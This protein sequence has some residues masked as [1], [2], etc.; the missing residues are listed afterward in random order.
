MDIVSRTSK[1]T[2]RDMARSIVEDIQ[3]IPTLD[4]CRRIADEY[5]VR[6]CYI[7]PEYLLD[8]WLEV[9]KERSKT[10]CIL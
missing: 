4:A 5:S 7:K 1:S 8:I 10:E 6:G 3:E 2:A 9:W